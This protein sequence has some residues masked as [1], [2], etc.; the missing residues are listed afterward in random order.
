[1]RLNLK[2]TEED[3]TYVNAAARLRAISPEMLLIRVLHAV[4][5]DQMILA[6]LDDGDQPRHYK[7]RHGNTEPTRLH[8]A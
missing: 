6:I 5:V 7:H 4:L 1:M 3:S 2:L 8:A